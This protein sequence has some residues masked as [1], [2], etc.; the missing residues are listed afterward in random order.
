MCIFPHVL[1]NKYFS[2]ITRVFGYVSAGRYVQLESGKKAGPPISQPAGC[3]AKSA[4]LFAK[5]DELYLFIQHTELMLYSLT[6]I[7]TTWLVMIMV[8]SKLFNNSM[9]TIQARV[10]A[11]RPE[12]VASVAHR[13]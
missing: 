4:Y 3:S 7:P 11:K 13:R 2:F 6:I 5:Y 10:K 12:V 1:Q 8:G 9:A